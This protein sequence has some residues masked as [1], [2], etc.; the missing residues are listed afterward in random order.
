[1]TLRRIVRVACLVL[2]GHFWLACASAHAAV[3]YKTEIAVP[4]D[5]QLAD[6]LTASSLLVAREKRGADDEAT[7]IRRANADLKRLQDVTSAAGYYDAKLSYRIDKSVRPWRVRVD[8]ALGQPYRLREVRLVTPKGEPPPLAEHFD[9]GQFGLQLGARATSASIVDG[10]NRILRFYTSKG[11]PLAKM[12]SREAVIDRADH[13]MHVTFTL[14]PG[15][16]AMFG[17]TEISGLKSVDR[18][19]VKRRIGWHEG[20]FYDSAKVEQSQQTLV[21]SNLFATVK[22]SHADKVGP[23]GRIAMRIEL[24]ERQRRSIGFGVFYD[25][26]LGLGTRAFWEHRNLFGEGELLHLEATVG[27]S[28]YG[29]LA[30]FRRPWFLRRDLDFRA[31]IAAQKQTLDAY[32]SRSE[33]VFAGIDEHFSK[34]VTGGA[35]LEVVQAH[36]NDD[37][38]VQDYALV[39]APLYIR[40][41]TTDDLLNPTRGTRLGLTATPYTSIDSSKLTFVSTKAVANAYQRL[42]PTDR[43]VLAEHA[44]LGSIDGVSLFALP[45]DLRL[46]EGGGGSVRGYGYQMA[47]PLDGLGN[48]IGG[49]SSLE[50]GLELRSKITETIGVVGFIEGGNV[51]TQSLPDLAQDLFWGAGA[52]VR[53][54]TPIGPVRLDLATPLD[55]RPQD[56]PIQL[57]ISLGQAF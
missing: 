26:S 34:T 49:L 7:L 11:R 21:D 42:G 14:N 38:G 12:V 30:Q 13:S 57:Y 17:A 41:D 5:D 25:T 18:R 45:A 39:G 43:F 37:R 33:S 50:L 46:Y 56:S 15:P 55:K 20:E 3:A 29:A 32:D 1:V 10:E 36:V 31:E 47:G 28:D 8:V 35:G 23:D 40:R 44:G 16:P 2:A 22:I 51:Y 48:P 19:F 27:Q 9:P 54:Y 53:Y 4:G 52:G 6:T 24:S